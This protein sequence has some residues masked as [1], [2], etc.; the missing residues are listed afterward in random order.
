MYL[1]FAGDT[2][3]AAGGWH[4]FR[5]AFGVLDDAVKEGEILIGQEEGKPTW[6][7]CADWYHVV[8]T[9]SNQIIHQ[10]GQAC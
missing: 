5:G 1:L 9:V 3:Y 6:E 4:D 2:F 8:E 7:R 10:V